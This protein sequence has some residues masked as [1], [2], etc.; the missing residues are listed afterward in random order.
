M[1]G[2][3]KLL[4]LMAAPILILSNAMVLLAGPEDLRTKALT[5]GEI[6]DRM[7]RA[8]RE[9]ELQLRDYEVLR[10]YI[11]HNRFTGKKAKLE[12][13]MHY[14][15]GEKQFE[16]ESEQGSKFLRSRVLKRLIRAEQEASTQERK[17]KTD[18]TEENYQFSLERVEELPYGRYYVLRVK[19]RRKDKYLL[20]GLIWVIDGDFAIVQIVGRPVRRPSFWTRRIHFVHQ[21]TKV[22]DFWLPA[23][24][25]TEVRVFLFGKTTVS[26][27]Y[28]GYRVSQQHPLGE[29]C[30]QE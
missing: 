8:Q 9:R 29:D 25:Q 5:L 28:H 23:S 17:Q 27:R 2:S 22:N 12:V 18:I 1:T 30:R 19:P 13:R 16:L 11:V 10:T 20:D 7:Q 26:I 6:V 21:Y 3:H 15:G 14:S 4:S 24:N